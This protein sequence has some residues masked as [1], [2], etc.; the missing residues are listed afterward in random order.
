MSDTLSTNAGLGY[1]YAASV[2]DDTFISDFLIFTAVTFPSLWL[3]R[4][5]F[6]SKDRR[7]PVF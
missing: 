3:V 7:A 5:F 6:R 4:K 1:L 2:A